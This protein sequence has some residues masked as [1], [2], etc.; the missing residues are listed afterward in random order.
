MDVPR[1]KALIEAH[2]QSLEYFRN[3]SVQTKSSEPHSLLG[4]LPNK[5]R[6]RIL[7]DVPGEPLSK[8]VMRAFNSCNLV[9]HPA[10]EDL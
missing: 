8:V 10:L 9:F 6:V 2:V 3:V 5:E 1:R 7:E 4:W